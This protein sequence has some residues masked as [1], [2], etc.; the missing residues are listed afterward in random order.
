[1][2][3]FRFEQ[4][5]L[6]NGDLTEF[7]DYIGPAYGNALRQSI[8]RARNNSDPREIVTIGA[9]LHDM[10]VLGLNVDDLL[11]QILPAVTRFEFLVDSQI[12]VTSPDGNTLLHNKS[13]TR[14]N[15]APIVQFS[16]NLLRYAPGSGRFKSL[17]AQFPPGGTGGQLF[18]K[19][20]AGDVTVNVFDLRFEEQKPTPG[21]TCPVTVP[22]SKRKG[23]MP[24]VSAVISFTDPVDIWVHS[25]FGDFDT[26]TGWDSL[27]EG[28]ESSHLYEDRTAYGP[29]TY[30]F[31]SADWEYVGTSSLFAYAQLQQTK[32]SADGSGT[33]EETT[34]IYLMYKPKSVGHF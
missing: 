4:L 18:A 23:R 21:Q 16:P 22:Y 24:Q 25:R 19:L 14:T 33:A 7:L 6:G 2:R 31:K 9:L 34:T 26:M 20:K 3:F 29:Y 5:L 30:A 17:E 13:D 10:S 27:F 8:A 12:E 32:P 15:K 28:L 1:V 11:D